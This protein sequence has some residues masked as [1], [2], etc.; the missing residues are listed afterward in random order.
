M[1]DISVSSV[2]GHGMDDRS[3]T[4]CCSTD[5]IIDMT[6]EQRNQSRRSFLGNDSV[7]GYRGNE[8]ARNN[9]RTA[10]SMQCEVNTPL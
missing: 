6:P 9:R 5:I 1:G 3:S 8:H 2:N 7:T 10:V 4:L